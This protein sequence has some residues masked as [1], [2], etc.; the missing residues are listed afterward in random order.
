MGNNQAR[1]QMLD[2][3]MVKRYMEQS[4]IYVLKQYI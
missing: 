2:T 3:Q 4:F 1:A